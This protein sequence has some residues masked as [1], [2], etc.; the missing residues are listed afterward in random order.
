MAKPEEVIM[1]RC[2]FWVQVFGLPLRLMNAKIGAVIGET[3]G[4]VEEI[5]ID[6]DSNAWGCSVRVR[7][8]LNISKA[9]LRGSRINIEGG[10][11][12][13]V[14]YKYENLPDFCYVC[15]KLTH[16]E[17]DC[18]VAAN[19]NKRTGKIQRNY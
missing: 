2:P 19:M 15:G 16:Q 12:A 5:D 18:D 4:D 9:L 17:N 10:S 8:N 13:L 14:L 1:D 7:V 3:L 11:K 6:S